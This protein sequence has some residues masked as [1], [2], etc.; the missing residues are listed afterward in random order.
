MF[1]S[2]ELTKNIEIY[3]AGNIKTWF[4]VPYKEPLPTYM[5]GERDDRA[6]N[7]RIHTS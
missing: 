6:S 2:T 7:P 5:N 4:D 1:C 3:P